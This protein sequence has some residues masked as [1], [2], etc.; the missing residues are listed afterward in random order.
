[1]I[2]AFSV[3]PV[4][5]TLLARSVRTVGIGGVG[6]E[7]GG[8]G[9]AGGGVGVE[10]GGGGLAGGG[11]GVEGGGVGVEGDGVGVEGGV[12]VETGFAL[13]IKDSSRSL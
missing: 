6:V 11:V 3:A 1:M 8:A 2:V 13:I 4:S 9:L 10:G 5:F 7:G 12:G